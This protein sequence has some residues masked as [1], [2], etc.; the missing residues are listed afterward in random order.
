MTIA[1]IMLGMLLL[2]AA[3]HHVVSSAYKNFKIS[4]GYTEIA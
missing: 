4:R 3:A 1:Y 2:V